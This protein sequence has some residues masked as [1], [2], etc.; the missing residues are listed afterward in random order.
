MFSLY[1]IAIPGKMK[2]ERR[3]KTV[4]LP[5]LG[6]LELQ[7]HTLAFHQTGSF[8]FLLLFL[9]TFWGIDFGHFCEVNPSGGLHTA[10]VRL[11]STVNAST[12]CLVRRE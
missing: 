9:K 10:N 12:S 2:R 1:C 7:R 4:G 6:E 5:T 11:S 8:S 3:V